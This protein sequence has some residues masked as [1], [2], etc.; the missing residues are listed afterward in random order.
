ML[1]VLH[2]NVNYFS[3]KL[4]IDSTFFLFALKLGNFNFV[5]QY[6]WFI[7]TKRFLLKPVMIQILNFIMHKSFVKFL[8]YY[9]LLVPTHC[10]FFFFWF[11]C[12]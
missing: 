11:I 5:I 9:Y 4:L 10:F 2:K 6:V 12:K 1:K 7:R 3:M 8:I